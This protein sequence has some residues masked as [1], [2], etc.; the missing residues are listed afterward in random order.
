[1]AWHKALRILC[2]PSEV[3][4]EGVYRQLTKARNY[5]RSI[6]TQAMNPLVSEGAN[7]SGVLGF[8]F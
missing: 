5:A 7:L 6:L 2:A 1:M 8:Q 3:S 4:D